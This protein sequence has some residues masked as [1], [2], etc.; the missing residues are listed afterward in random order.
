VTDTVRVT[1]EHNHS[2][3][4]RGPPHCDISWP[5][6][7]NPTDSGGTGGVRRDLASAVVAECLGDEIAAMEDV[8][9]G[10]L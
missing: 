6:P 7:A 2:R 3:C 8:V 1:V 9:V 5:S 4:S 10:S